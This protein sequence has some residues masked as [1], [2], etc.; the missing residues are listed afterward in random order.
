MDDSD[1]ITHGLAFKEFQCKCDYKD[2]GHQFIF[3][4]LVDKYSIVRKHFGKPITITSGYRCQRH[5][6]NVGGVDSS[7]HKIGAAIDL[8]CEANDLPRLLELCKLF[9]DT[10]IHYE[11]KN[12]IHCQ[13]G[14]INED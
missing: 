12:F 5:N 11:D 2:C 8:T 10:V 7:Y 14:E 3:Q 13:L 9:F 4:K 6:S 1:L